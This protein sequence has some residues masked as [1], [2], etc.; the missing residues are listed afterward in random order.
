MFADSLDVQ[1]TVALDAALEQHR[2]S[3]FAQALSLL[4]R[5]L[6]VKRDISRQQEK[7]VSK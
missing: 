1:A 3:M 6:R 2:Q 7:A 4:A 5:K